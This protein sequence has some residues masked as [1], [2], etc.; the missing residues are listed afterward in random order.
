MNQLIMTLYVGYWTAPATPGMS[1]TVQEMG[2][3]PTIIS[4]HSP[5][6]HIVHD[7]QQVCLVARVL[8]I[9]EDTREENVEPSLSPVINLDSRENFFCVCSL[10]TPGVS[11]N[12]ICV[13]SLV[14]IA[15]MFFLVVFA[16]LD[17]GQTKC[18]T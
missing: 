13:S 14:M 12:T 9:W 1:N 4:Y 10:T 3:T 5:V 7:N 16:L 11:R 15:L 18:P 2:I 17:S 8:R 6:G